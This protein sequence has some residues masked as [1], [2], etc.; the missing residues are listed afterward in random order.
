MDWI[1]IAIISF[2]VWAVLKVYFKK[3]KMKLLF[4][5]RTEYDAALQGDDIAKVRE[6]GRRYYTAV[7]NGTF[8]DYAEQIMTNEI[9]TMMRSDKKGEED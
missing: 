8:N 7:G 4:D 1:V 3:M 9:R 6:A 5:L 2:T